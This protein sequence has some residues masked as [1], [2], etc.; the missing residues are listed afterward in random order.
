MTF[1]RDVRE[2]ER[3]STVRPVITTRRGLVPDLDYPDGRLQR[4]RPEHHA[5]DDR[6]AASDAPGRIDRGL[7]DAW[8]EDVV[9]QQ[10]TAQAIVDGD[11]TFV[12]IDLRPR[13]VRI[14]GRVGRAGRRRGSRCATPSLAYGGVRRAGS[15]HQ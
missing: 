2:S 7:D 12:R 13:R 3:A 4:N 1:K 6:A 11:R 8:R 9:R 5:L 14:D 10:P 15:K